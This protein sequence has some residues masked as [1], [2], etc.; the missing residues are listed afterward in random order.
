[1]RCTRSRNDTSRR[2]PPTLDHPSPVPPAEDAADPYLEV[3]FAA[4]VGI[5]EDVLPGEGREGL[6]ALDQDVDVHDAHG[7]IP[8]IL[9]VPHEGIPLPFRHL[10]LNLGEGLD[11]LPL[12]CAPVLV[13]K[14]MDRLLL[15]ARLLR[16]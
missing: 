2:F 10:G 5:R 1:M 8:R 11:V 13:E 6:V 12:E 14:P 9:E 15:R 4:A 16:E 3:D 7:E